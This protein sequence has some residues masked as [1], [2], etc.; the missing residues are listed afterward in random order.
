MKRLIVVT[1]V[2]CIVAT[3]YLFYHQPIILKAATGSARVLSTPV[4]AIIKIDGQVQPTARCFV[5]KSRF[6]GS[7]ADS[8]V[9]WLPDA[10]AIYGRDVLIVDRSHQ[11]VGRPNA[12]NL[13]YYLLWDRFLFQ[14]ES[15]ARY[16]SFKSPKTDSQDPQLEFKD[17]H[18]KFVVARSPV[19]EGKRIEIVFNS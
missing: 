10:G 13:D 1:A 2:I 3:V 4:E 12:S 7:P 17:K 11:D 6:D 5:V 9:L 19:L 14:S 18:I 8:L 15:G 16:V